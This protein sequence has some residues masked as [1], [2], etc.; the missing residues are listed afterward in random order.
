MLK[1]TFLLVM[2][3]CKALSQPYYTPIRAS[4]GAEAFGVSPKGQVYAEATFLNRKKSFC[5]VSAGFGAIWQADFKSYTF[6][7]SLTYAYLLNPYRRKPL[8]AASG[9]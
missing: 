5:N 7:S 1:P 2:F 4:I 6:S 8:P 3:A 9:L